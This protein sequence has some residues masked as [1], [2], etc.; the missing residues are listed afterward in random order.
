M[1]N[2][3]EAGQIQIHAEG[4]L[5]ESEVRKNVAYCSAGP[6]ESAYKCPVQGTMPTIGQYEMVRIGAISPASANATFRDVLKSSTL[7]GR[8]GGGCLIGA[9]GL[10]RGLWLCGSRPRRIKDSG[11]VRTNAFRPTPPPPRRL[12]QYA[13]FPVVN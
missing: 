1:P 4:K 10:V 8:S 2:C 7:H 3:R 9:P 6:S 12:P 11:G 13:I 5:D